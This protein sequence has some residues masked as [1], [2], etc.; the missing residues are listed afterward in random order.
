MNILPK[1]NQGNVKYQFLINGTELREGTSHPTKYNPPSLMFVMLAIT[2]VY[3]TL[4]YWLP[5]RGIV[6]PITLWKIMKN[7]VLKAMPQ[8]F[9]LNRNSDYSRFVAHGGATKM[10]YD[11]WAGVG[12]RL[13][14]S[15][16][17]VALDVNKK[18]ATEGQKN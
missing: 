11:T 14:N 2:I 12:Q 4:L 15:M 18:Q 9:S 16:K 3:S 1:G 8:V 17:K 13:N 7:K 10:M 6:I 5:I